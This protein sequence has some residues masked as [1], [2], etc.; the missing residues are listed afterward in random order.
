MLV[1][2]AA[3]FQKI[4]RKDNFVCIRISDDFHLVCLFFC[5]DLRGWD[6]QSM[7]LGTP[8]SRCSSFFVPN[9]IELL[10]A[11]LVVATGLWGPMISPQERGSVFLVFFHSIEV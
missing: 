6:N 2:A 9:S 8:I 11:Y 10:L 1:L 4:N 3:A 7:G 5:L